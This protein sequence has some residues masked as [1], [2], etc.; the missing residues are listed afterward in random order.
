MNLRILLSTAAFLAAGLAGTAAA[1]NC[2]GQKDG[3][4][5]G[6]H[7]GCGR[8]GHDGGL[9]VGIVLTPG[10]RRA[11]VPPPP[12]L[13]ETVFVNGTVYEIDGDGGNLTPTRP[14]AKAPETDALT[15]K[16]RSEIE[17]LK[18]EGKWPLHTKISET[19]GR[20]SG[21]RMRIEVIEEIIADA[22]GTKADTEKLKD[23]NEKRSIKPTSSMQKTAGGFVAGQ[24]GEF[25]ALHALGAEAGPL[26]IIAGA[27]ENGLEAAVK[28][29]WKRDTRENLKESIKTQAKNIADLHRVETALYQDL[30]TE[31]GR[32]KD[33]EQEKKDFEKLQDRWAEDQ[34]RKQAEAEKKLPATRRA[35]TTRV[36]DE[37]GDRAEQKQHSRDQAKRGITPSNR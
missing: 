33:L 22:E 11:Y 13:D 26:G 29:K 12:K 35:V 2:G 37:A 3:G 27:I 20:I 25:A 28:Y 24:A 21:L 31:H 7:P 5:D 30:G 15:E 6:G 36:D 17:R 9:G 10:Q 4:K 16:Y 14:A 19:N 34:L 18:A 1:Q 23:E 32:M 8:G